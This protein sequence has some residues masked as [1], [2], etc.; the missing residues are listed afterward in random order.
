MN[1]NTTELVN[2]IYKEAE[3]IDISLILALYYPK[4][5]VAIPLTTKI[6]DMDIESLELSVRSYNCL[7][8]AGIANVRELV[9][10]IHNG[11]FMRIRNLGKKSRIEI[12]EK[13]LD[14][15]Y[16]ALSRDEKVEFIIDTVER[17]K[18]NF[19]T[20]PINIDDVNFDID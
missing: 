6:C 2:E 14:I 4:H 7:K 5:S 17:N 19:R 1:T 9:A 18:D 20:E 11:E 12:Q 13:L 3:R 10:I 8:R 16:A 15:G